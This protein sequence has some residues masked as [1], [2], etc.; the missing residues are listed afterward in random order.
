MNREPEQ[1]TGRFVAFWRRL[2]QRVDRMPT[3]GR[4]SGLY[5][6]FV[7]VSLVLWYF[8]KL[9]YEYTAEI[10]VP[11]RLKSSPQGQLLVGS[12]ERSVVLRLRGTGTN[13]L[14]YRMLR[15]MR[16][17]EIDLR[18]SQRDFIFRG[19]TLAYITGRRLH[20]ILARQIPPELVLDAVISDTLTCHFSRLVRR[21]LPVHAEV[22]YSLA[23]QHL[24]TS[25]MRITPDSMWVSG[26][27]ATLEAM[28]DVTCEP[29]ELGLL[30]SSA[31][32]SLNVIRRPDAYYE[33]TQVE[34]R[35]GV[36]Q[37]T[38]KIF[39]VPITVDNVPDSLTVTLLPAMATLQCN[40]PLSSYGALEAGQFH[41]RARLGRI[42]RNN[43]LM[44]EIDSIPPQAYAV[45]FEP[46]YVQYIIEKRTK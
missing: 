12:P 11:I 23:D 17:P 13:L 31:Q 36:A 37:Y 30:R 33:Q 32:S 9:N 15:G 42:M 16:V 21:R 41:L 46:K 5:L 20:P 6:I 29:C 14:R 44:V 7:L 40:V 2:R 22:Q 10:E 18:E 1:P 35:I 25:P 34:V 3:R 4:N 24:Q 27:Q 28:E 19:D 26:P 39:Q 38:E 43:R 8:N 45:N